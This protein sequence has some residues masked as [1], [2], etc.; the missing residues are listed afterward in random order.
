MRA[1]LVTL[2]AAVAL[3]AC[4]KPQDI[5]FGPE[6][7][8]QIAEQGDHFKKLPEADRMLLVGYLGLSEV[9]KAFGGD[10]KPVTGRTVGEVL[11]DARAWKAQMDAEK[12]AQ[13][14]KAKEAEALKAKALAE[15]K[16]IV[17]R[18]AQSATVAAVSMKILPKNYDAGRFESM[19]TFNYVIENKGTV[20]IRQLK[21]T[22]YFRDATGDP[23][24]DLR[25]NFDEP[26]AAGKT[27][28]TD[29]GRGW[30]INEFRNGDIEKIAGRDF[31]SM[32]VSFEPTSV[33]FEGGEVL[34]APDAN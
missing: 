15:R 30:T 24:G 27:L 16:V 7:L 19:L 1:T 14:E 28:K 34:K 13:A 2:V 5:V 17:D 26:I 32:T 6:P 25:V 23:I 31:S 12:A 22:L 10:S 18:I 9:R 20:G 11:V 4:S 8:K 21:G 29:T 3:A 33:A